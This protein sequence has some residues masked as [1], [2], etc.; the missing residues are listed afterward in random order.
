MEKDAF[1]NIIERKLGEIDPFF[2]ALLVKRNMQTFSSF[3]GFSDENINELA[4]ETQNYISN[5]N[6]DSIS[7]GDFLKLQPDLSKE[8]KISLGFKGTIKSICKLINNNSYEDFAKSP[9]AK[10]KRVAN[11]SY[12]RNNVNMLSLDNSGPSLLQMS[13]QEKAFWDEKI[14]SKAL[15]VLGIEISNEITLGLI[16]KNRDKETV[17]NKFLFK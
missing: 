12:S 15:K 9:P 14:K 8:F 16:Q 10:K 4:E 13:E 7:Y 17:Q 3:E 5:L 6:T 11:Q 2:K 1:W